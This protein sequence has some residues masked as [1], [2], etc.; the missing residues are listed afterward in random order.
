MRFCGITL[1]QI[2]AVMDFGDV[3]SG[4][5]GGWIE[6]AKNLSND[7]NAWIDS[8]ARIWGNTRIW[9]DAKVYGNARI[10]GNVM[11]WGNA[12]VYGDAMVWGNT[13]VWENAKVYGNA[14]VYDNVMV[15]G[16]AEVY[17][18]AGVYGNAE[19][20]GDA[21]VRGSA[22]VCSNA[23]VFMEN[24]VLVIG[25]VGSRNDF[26]TFYRDKDNDIAVRCG[27]FNGKVQMFLEQV[28]ETHGDNRHALVYQAAAELAKI[29]IDLSSEAQ[30]EESEL[31][32]EEEY[33]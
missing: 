19:V 20:Y 28:S 14:R 17:D 26:A 31:K 11:V 8:D 1:K 10:C 21:R 33:A 27:C 15:W 7:G 12:E 24:H 13:E 29:S 25:A 5:V 22:E 3:V 16:N 2:V 9:G 4:D 18:N 23:R 6:G 32:K 30:K